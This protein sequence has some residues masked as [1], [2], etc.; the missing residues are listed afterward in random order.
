MYRRAPDNSFKEEPIQ[1]AVTAGIG[2]NYKINDRLAVLPN[3]EFRII[4][5][6]IRN[7]L[8]YERNG[9]LI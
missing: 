1:L 7:W 3:P 4:S 6:Q 5:K 9:R 2:I 8:R